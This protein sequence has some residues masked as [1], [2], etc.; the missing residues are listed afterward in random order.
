MRKEF[1]KWLLDIAKYLVTVLL[2]S[3]L[4]ADMD[5]TYMYVGVSALVIFI[6]IVG[7]YL[8]DDNDDKDNK[9]NKKKGK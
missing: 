9:T 8:V 3:S 5:R 2:L 6:F 4:F 1:G 7:L